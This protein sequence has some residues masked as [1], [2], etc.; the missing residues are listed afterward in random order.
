MEIRGH[1]RDDEVTLALLDSPLSSGFGAKDPRFTDHL[2]A[3]AICRAEQERLAARFAGFGAW[4]RAD[5]ERPENF[6]EMQHAHIAARV[7]PA[8]KTARVLWFGFALAG[9]AAVIVLAFA[10]FGARPY[11]PQVATTVDDHYLLVD[12]EHSINNELPAALEPAA[13]LANEMNRNASPS[14]QIRK[15]VKEN[16]YA[17]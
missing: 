10:I 2:E 7:V 6:W 9:V 16:H 5:A 4:A 8:A 12:V 1:L 3:C 17:N 11:P 15:A 14:T 13:L